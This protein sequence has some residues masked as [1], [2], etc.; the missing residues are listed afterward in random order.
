M[1]LFKMRMNL[2]GSRNVLN[3]NGLSER[4]TSSE[5]AGLKGG[6][7]E[8]EWHLP[9]LAHSFVCLARDCHMLIITSLFCYHGLLVSFSSLSLVRASPIL[10]A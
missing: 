8:G 6:R 7:N 4:R 3:G 1:L 9:C 2:V 10:V 5:C